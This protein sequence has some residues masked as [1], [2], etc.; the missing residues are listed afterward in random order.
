LGFL[1]QFHVILKPLPVVSPIHFAILLLGVLLIALQVIQIER[2]QWLG[3]PFVLPVF[4]WKVLLGLGMLLTLF[5][6]ARWPSSDRRVD[7]PRSVAYPLF[8]V[9]FGVGSYLRFKWLGVP[10]SIYWDDH[11][12]TILDGLLV[13]DLHKYDLA[14]PY[15]SGAVMGIIPYTE[16]FLWWLFPAM[17]ALVVQRVAENL[18]S[19]AALWMVY[20]LGREISGKR[21]VG[22]LAMAFM[23]ASRPMVMLSLCGMSQPVAF[24]VIA[25][26][27]FFQ[28]RLFKKP[29]LRHFV[30]WGIALGLGSYAYLI[31]YPWI[32]FLLLVTLGWLLW[33]GRAQKSEWPLLVVLVFGIGF[34]GFFLD[35][36]LNVFHDNFFARVW[37]G[38]FKLW[39]FWQALFLALFIHCYRISQE[40][41]RRLCAWGMGT[42]LAGVVSYP[43]AVSPYGASKIATVSLFP[44]GLF[45]ILDPGFAKMI[46]SQCLVIY[47]EF[48]IS[49]DDRPDMN[50]YYDPFF[51]YHEVV[52]ICVGFLAFVIR[53]SWLKGLLFGSVFIGI[54]PRIFTIDAHSTKI[55][56]AVLPLLLLAAMAVSEWVEG[57]WC[58]SGGRKWMGTL[59]ALGVAA[60]WGWEVKGTYA[61]TFDKSGFPGW[62]SVE[63]EETRLNDQIELDK[64]DKR[65]YVVPIRGVRFV[66]VETMGVLQDRSPLY[67]YR[68]ANE[69][70][71]GPGEKPRDVV[72]LV[73]PF[74]TREIARL[75]KDFPSAEW[76]SIWLTIRSPN[77]QRLAYRVL[78]P[79]G[80]IPAKPG[81]SFW[82]HTVP[83]EN[84][85]C[86]VYPG[87]ALAR[88]GM[89]LSESSK[90]T[91]NPVDPTLQKEGGEYSLLAEGEWEAP[92]DG[93]YTFSV[94]TPDFI[95]L[96]LDDKCLIDSRPPAG[97]V[98]KKSKGIRLKKGPHRIRYATMNKWAFAD[99]TVRNTDL[100]WERVLGAK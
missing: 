41:A 99:V 80:K 45:G 39:V 42:L 87:Y 11:S 17:K 83:R 10:T 22:L 6:L 62:W 75:K 52:F 98:A 51:D 4:F 18:F 53:P 56:G 25:S 79:A 12:V 44:K 95:R 7:L 21:L 40:R 1:R 96:E 16:A 23:A 27:L 20:R 67:R 32:L 13:A 9:I 59:L 61:K 14:F 81:K 90:P 50:V 65:I 24:F 91:L 88:A 72:V 74:S 77:L 3:A 60:F 46:L 33:Q 49:D 78:I 15:G 57:A 84:W 43:M 29:D 73:S 8:A 30:Q 37:G 2:Y 34:F 47:K 5:G 76:T 55:M 97:V 54:V 28:V 26:Y 89:I 66:S 82:F 63:T 68:D 94:T 92:A 86:R 69:I 48:F 93:L 19:L 31:V 70:P 71:L 100:K 35:S 85:L 38:N 64:A 36:M 58:S